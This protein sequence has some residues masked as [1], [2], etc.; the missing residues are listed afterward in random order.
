MGYKNFCL[1]P[2]PFYKVNFNNE[3]TW[4]AHKDIFFKGFTSFESST[5]SGMFIRHINRRLQ[6][7]KLNSQTDRSDARYIQ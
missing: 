7:T 3:C 5:Q 2:I 6:M 4:L 1:R